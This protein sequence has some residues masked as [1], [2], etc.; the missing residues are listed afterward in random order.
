MS[1][2]LDSVIMLLS[3]GSADEK[4]NIAVINLMEYQKEDI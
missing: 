4:I 2:R 3:K 1:A